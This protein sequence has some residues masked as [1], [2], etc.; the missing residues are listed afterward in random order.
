MFS[1]IVQPCRKCLHFL[2]ECQWA[3]SCTAYFI[4]CLFSLIVQSLTNF[5][6]KNVLTPFLPTIGPQWPSSRSK[7][8]S[9]IIFVSPQ[10]SPCL[11]LV[12]PVHGAMPRSL[13]SQK[14]AQRGLGSSRGRGTDWS[15]FH[16][17]GGHGGYSSAEG[18][19]VDADGAAIRRGKRP[20]STRELLHIMDAARHRPRSCCRVFVMC[21]FAVAVGL[22]V[23]ELVQLRWWEDASNLSFVLSWGPWAVAC[24]VLLL[25]ILGTC[26][27]SVFCETLA[28]LLA[29]IL[30]PAQVL[31]LA[32]VSTPA[33][34]DFCCCFPKYCVM[35]ESDRGTIGVHLRR[36]VIVANETCA[37][38]VPMS[39]RDFSCASSRWTFVA[40][41]F[42][43]CL[44]LIWATVLVTQHCQ[45]QQ[46]ITFPS[47]SSSRVVSSSSLEPV[48]PTDGGDGGGGGRNADYELG[49]DAGF[50]VRDACDSSSSGSD[51][52]G[53]GSRRRRRK[54]KKKKKKKQKKKKSKSKHSRKGERIRH[55]KSPPSGS[56]ASRSSSSSSSSSSDDASEDRMAERMAEPQSRAKEARQ[57]LRKLGSARAYELPPSA[58]PAPAMR[59]R[60]PLPST[61]LP[62]PPSSVFAEHTSARQKLRAKILEGASS[63]SAL[64]SAAA[65]APRVESAAAASQFLSPRVSAATNF[66]S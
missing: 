39:K 50:N 52:G 35:G 37:G 25:F 12:L 2:S 1:P 32:V 10:V 46:V 58:P 23:P 53:G 31:Q 33:A 64:A 47:A 48:E 7:V 59:A 44:I 18:E 41:W 11:H 66:L 49:A 6:E 27:R 19:E 54:R 38:I 28:S 51:D 34:L 43:S 60:L 63:T 14:R 9:F 22:A 65:A 55:R 24:G 56:S 13:R 36:P 26:C 29:V 5:S 42:S 40:F 8:C 20:R 57:M 21:L 30:I 16:H 62:A 3:V 17:G 15:F 45:K 61:A 4:L